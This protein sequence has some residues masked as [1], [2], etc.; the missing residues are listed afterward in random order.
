M[1]SPGA[2]ESLGNVS[3][4]EGTRCVN[5]ARDGVN[6]GAPD[7][8]DPKPPGQPAVGPTRSPEA[9]NLLYSGWNVSRLVRMVP[10]DNREP[11]L[12]YIM[13]LWSPLG[14]HS[15]FQANA[16]PLRP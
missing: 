4:R 15:A 12:G 14:S 10:L 2:L 3:L 7:Q 6:Q 5:D 8:P 11:V 9:T 1:V 16:A 13:I